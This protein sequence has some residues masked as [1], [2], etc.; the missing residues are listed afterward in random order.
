MSVRFNVPVDE[1]PRPM[2]VDA[3]FGDKIKAPEPVMFPPSA[4]PSVVSVKSCVLAVSVEPV[5][6]ELPV[7]TEL[8]L[9]LSASW[10][11]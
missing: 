1:D 9:R 3:V 11:S 8:A 10:Y 5:V 2:V 7:R 6:I 4:N